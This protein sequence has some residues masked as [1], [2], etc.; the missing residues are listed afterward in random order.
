MINYK[1]ICLASKSPRRRQLLD[2]LGVQY[3]LL[4]ANIDETAFA[5]EEPQAYVKRMCCEKARKVW[6]AELFD[7]QVPVL[8][9][10]TAVILDHSI[11]GK[12]VDEQE[13]KS[14]LQQLSAREHWV[15]TGVVMLF[16]ETERFVLSQTKVCFKALTELDISAYWRTGE[17][18]DKAGS[19]AIQGK[20]ASFIERIEGS[21]SGV[22]GLPLFETTQLLEAFNVDY[23]KAET[24]A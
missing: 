22:M 12:P 16:N 3:D 14:M 19:Y 17:G 1:R 11:L 23:W 6:Q 10:D 5:G 8:A 13:G 24:L 9:S 4:A 20:A 7:R 21:F 2:Q 18:R 15:M